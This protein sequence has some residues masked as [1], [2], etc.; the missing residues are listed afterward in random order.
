MKPDYGL[1][2]PVVVRNLL[3]PETAQRS[4]RGHAIG[5]TVWESGTS[6]PPLTTEANTGGVS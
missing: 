3:L 2:A 4:R 1:D 6:F 5:E